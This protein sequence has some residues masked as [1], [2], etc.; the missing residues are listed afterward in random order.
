VCNWN[1]AKALPN[2]SNQTPGDPVPASTCTIKL[3]IIAQMGRNSKRDEN[4]G[5]GRTLVS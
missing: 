2:M 5:F 4:E 1:T 3:A